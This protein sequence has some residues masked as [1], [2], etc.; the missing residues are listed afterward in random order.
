MIF[1]MK[2]DESYR[3]SIDRKADAVFLRRKSG[4]VSSV[5]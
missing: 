4:T 5:P 3:A 1:S 2:S